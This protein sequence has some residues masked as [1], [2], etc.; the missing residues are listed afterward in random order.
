MTEWAVDPMLQDENS[1][2][3]ISCRP[4]RK[5]CISSR[6]LA[7]IQEQRHVIS[8]FYVGIQC[9]QILKF[10]GV[11]GLYGRH[12]IWMPGIMPEFLYSVGLAW[13]WNTYYFNF[14]NGDSLSQGLHQENHLVI[15]KLSMKKGGFI[16][17][18]KLQS[19]FIFYWDGNIYF[20]IIKRFGWF[21]TVTG[22]H[23]TFTLGIKFAYPQTI[24]KYL[25][26][27]I[28]QKN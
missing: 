12:L 21:F 19:N 26:E 9:I 18:V 11:Y 15:R 5:H 6:T 17:P 7:Y 16:L 4:V 28:I 8:S 1:D 27:K 13:H 22:K 3:G 25:K 24:S 2:P 14:L 23:S 10:S 20:I